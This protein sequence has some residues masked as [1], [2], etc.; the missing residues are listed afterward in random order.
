MRNDTPMDGTKLARRYLPLVLVLALQAVIITVVPSTAHKSSPQAATAGIYQ[1]NGAAGGNGGG[2]G[3]GTGATTT[4]TTDNAGSSGGGTAAT[5]GGT[6]TTSGGGSTA[7]GSSGGGS[8]GGSAQAAGTTGGSGG[9]DT[10]HCVS[11]RQFDPK[12]DYY[13]PPCT[14]KFSGNNGGSTYRGV[15]KDVIEVVFYVSDYGAEVNAILQAEGLYVSYS[16]EQAF[17]KA[18]TKFLNDHYELYGRKIH[19]DTYKG[20]CQS[21]PPDKQCLIPE[22]DKIVAQ[23]K[24]FAVIWP[25]TLCSECFAELARKGVVNLGGSGFSEQFAQANRPFHWDYHMT[26]TKMATSFAQWWC[27]QL[28]SASKGRKVKFAGTQNP[29]Q[30][31]NGKD[32]VLGVISTNDPDNM[33]TVKNVLYPALKKCGEKYVG[34]HEYFYDQNINTAAQ[35]VAAG[36]AAMDTPQNPAT[37]V[38]CLCDPVA[39]AFLYQ[40]EQNNNYYPEN[41]IATNQSMDTDKTGQSYTAPNGLACP[42]PQQGCEYDL[43]MG[44]SELSAGEPVNN[45]AGTRVWHAGGGQGNTPMESDTATQEWEYLNMLATMIEATGPNLTPANMEQAAGHIP[46]RGGGTTG[47]YLVS[48]SQNDHGWIS[49]VRVVYWD[50]HKKSVQ[51]GAAGSYVQI[52]GARKTLGQFSVLSEPPAPTDGRH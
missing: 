4:F 52:E 27:N 24:P 22:M 41:L 20:Q 33:F 32:R 16:Q 6:S 50:K 18:V 10:S 11:G 47:H 37:T 1:Q 8:G 2:G 14:P 19:I 17:D 29:A 21:V 44:L 31:F 43:A 34:D 35:Q 25:T 12:I 7:A 28:T 3:G 36:I 38:L 48:A 42:T 15:S 51:N 5:G 26:G 23:Y 9:G 39:P 40:G 49:D 45:D 46:A 30:N 13:A